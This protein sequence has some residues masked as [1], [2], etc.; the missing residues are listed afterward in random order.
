M[1]W[2]NIIYLP[3][4][5]LFNSRS[6][7]TSII[8]I[9]NNKYGDHQGSVTTLY[10]CYSWGNTNLRL[11]QY[12]LFGIEQKYVIRLHLVGENSAQFHLI[13][14]L[15]LSEYLALMIHAVVAPNNPVS[16]LFMPLES[17]CPHTAVINIYHKRHKYQWLTFN[18]IKKVL[19]TL[20]INTINIQF[21]FTLWNSHARFRNT[22]PW[23]LL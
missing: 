21:I 16:S 15:S 14:T 10:A 5:Y 17:T 9:Q 20:I 8:T 12:C 6:E 13:I 23:H 1:A 2:C 18:N 4:T 19:S 11:D 3:L 22:V 7:T